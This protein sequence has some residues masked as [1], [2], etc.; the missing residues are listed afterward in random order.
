MIYNDGVVPKDV[1]A[2]IAVMKSKR[3]IQF[4]DWCSTRFKVGINYQ[5]PTDIL[6]FD[7]A[8]I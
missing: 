6:S 7:L 2:A 5:P 4:V 1:D 8:K 3:S